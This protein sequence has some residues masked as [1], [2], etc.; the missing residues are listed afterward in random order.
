MGEARA[1]ASPGDRHPPP[2]HHFPAVLRGAGAESGVQGSGPREW[3]RRGD[4]PGAAGSCASRA[5]QMR[6]LLD[7]MPFSPGCPAGPRAPAT[8]TAGG[9]GRKSEGHNG[10]QG[11]VPRT[12]CLGLRSDFSVLS[13]CLLFSLPSVGR[14]TIPSACRASLSLGGSSTAFQGHHRQVA[15]DQGR[16]HQSPPTRPCDQPQAR[17]IPSQSP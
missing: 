13:V 10:T 4:L 5:S 9:R 6:F 2:S 1:P 17:G 15:W 12:P 7:P 16:A 14:A 3:V 8:P 11:L